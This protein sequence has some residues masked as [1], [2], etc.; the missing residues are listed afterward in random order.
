[1]Q[2]DW[3]TRIQDVQKHLV[4]EKIDGWLLYDFN[5]INT[6]ARDF[7]NIGNEELITRRFFY[8]VPAKGEPI[9]I[10]HVIEPHVLSNL[11][12]TI[13]QYLKWQELEA[14]LSQVLK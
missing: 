7:L 11:P 10:L 13:L 2:M 9:K 1:M 12:G 6:L 8:W 5:G 14:Q 3:H 4:R